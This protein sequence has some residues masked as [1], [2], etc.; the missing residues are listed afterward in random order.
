M[1]HGQNSW[2]SCKGI[3]LSVDFW[4]LNGHKVI[5]FL[6]DYLFDREK[7]EK[8]K[9][10]YEQQDKSVSNI[11]SSV[12]YGSPNKNASQGRRNNS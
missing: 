6:P 2:F 12:E 3:E 7:V 5:G 8:F 9:R 1:R 11:N 10:D 4:Q